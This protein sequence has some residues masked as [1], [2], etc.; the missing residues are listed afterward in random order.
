M[1]CICH[2]L[3]LEV[4]L[5]AEPAKNIPVIGPGRIREQTGRAISASANRRACAAVDAG[6]KIR[7]L[8][9]TRIKPCRTNSDSANGEGPWASATSHSA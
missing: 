3:A 1:N 5:L 6:L 4:A 2:Q 8:V 9:T 7:G